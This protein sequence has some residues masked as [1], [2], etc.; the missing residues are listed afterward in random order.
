MN[1]TNKIK[2]D[3]LRSW[4]YLDHIHIPEIPAE[5]ELLIGTN[6]SQLLEPWEVVNSQGG[7]PFAIKTHWGGLLVALDNSVK[8]IMSLSL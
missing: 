5:V 7:G 2:T 8:E 6:A 1:A 4:S 3:F